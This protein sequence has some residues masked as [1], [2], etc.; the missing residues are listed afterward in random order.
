[1]QCINSKD[2]ESVIM[3]LNNGKYRGTLAGQ[4]LQEG[5]VIG[6]VHAVGLVYANKQT[7]YEIISNRKTLVQNDVGLLNSLFD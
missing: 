2:T 4:R 5:L 1:M 3:N 6:F 7:Q